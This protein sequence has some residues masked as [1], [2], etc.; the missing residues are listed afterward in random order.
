MCEDGRLDLC[1]QVVGP[2]GIGPLLE[3]M[4]KT[5][6]I[7]ALLLGNNVVGDGGA[8]NIAEFIKTAPNRKVDPV[9]CWYIAGNDFTKRGIEEVCK[10]LQNDNIVKMLWLKR[11]P[12][13][14]GGCLPLS[15]MLM[16]NTTLSVLD[17]VNTG[18]LDEGTETIT[19]ALKDNKTLRHLYLGTNGITV[20]GAKCIADYIA[21]G[22][23]FLYSL[24]LSCN[25]LMNKGSI[26]LAEALP[27]DKI[28][29]L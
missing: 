21:G 27:K 13:L 29:S 8:K 17:L 9:T 24:Y 4:G 10:V 23:C 20:K 25:R 15:K 18:I 11:N 2:L 14:P 1:K 3:A 22:Y 6:V 12:L 7:D 5:S 16:V 19:T 28:K 26:L